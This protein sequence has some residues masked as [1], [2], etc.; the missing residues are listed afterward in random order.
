MCVTS[1]TRNSGTWTVVAKSD[2][3]SRTST[4][5]TLQDEGFASQFDLT[6]QSVLLSVL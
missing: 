6:L 4:G 2:V 5:K 3:W 1:Q